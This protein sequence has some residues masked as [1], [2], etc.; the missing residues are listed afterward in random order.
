[1]FGTWA[2][3]TSL[4]TGNGQGSVLVTLIDNSTVPQKPINMTWIVFFSVLLAAFLHAAWNSLV[5]GSQDKYVGMLLIALGHVPPGIAFV[6]FAPLPGLEVL[7]WLA[8]SLA[9][10]L[11]YQLFLAASYRVGDLTTVYPIARGSAPLFVTMISLTVLDVDLSLPQI[12]SV[13]LLVFGILLLSFHRFGTDK[14]QGI[15]LVLALVTGG[16][17]AS[18]SIVDGLG[19]RTMGHALAY[20]GWIAI[21][22]G[23][24]MTIWMMFFQP[25][26]LAKVRVDRQNI[27]T[28]LLGGGASYL[29]YGIVMWAFTQ[30]PIA[31]V[32]ALRETS[33]IFALLIGILFM[34]ER[35]T[36]IKIVACVRT[37]VG[38]VLLR[39]TSG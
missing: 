13:G 34:G 7:P 33:V 18:Y 16:F 27:Q 15:V 14:R 23:V 31:V 28:L 2:V 1:M 35:S 19:A 21:G 38:V 30:A 4:E 32:T 36:P 8:A 22:N 9:L 6:M 3:H 29:A 12:G 25:A 11:G 10:H 20:W 24:L 39:I 5:K 17:I 26:S 37:V